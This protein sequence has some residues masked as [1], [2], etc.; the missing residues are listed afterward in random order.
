MRRLAVIG[1]NAAGMSAAA[2]A[3]RRDPQLEV[4]VFERGAYT[5]YSSCGIPYFVA[6][7]VEGPDNLIARS[8]DEFRE[9]VTQIINQATGGV[10]P[11]PMVP[12][13]VPPVP[14][15]APMAPRP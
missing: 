11:I 13:P 15:P 10:P 6:G 1:G 3:R 2:V 7:L 12:A 9:G 14:T 5:S 4:L 8:A